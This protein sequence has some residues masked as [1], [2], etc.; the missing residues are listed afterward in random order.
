MHAPLIRTLDATISCGAAFRRTAGDFHGCLSNI[1]LNRAS[2]RISLHR[3]YQAFSLSDGVFLTSPCLSGT[4]LSCRWD[5]V[6]PPPTEI[7][8]RQLRRARRR[9]TPLSIRAEH[10]D[11]RDMR[12]QACSILH[13]SSVSIPCTGQPLTR[14]LPSTPKIATAFETLLAGV[15][16]S[17]GSLALRIRVTPLERGIAPDAIRDRSS[18]RRAP[19][20]GRTISPGNLLALTH[21]RLRRARGVTLSADTVLSR[22]CCWRRCRAQVTAFFCLRTAPQYNL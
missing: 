11:S 13:I 12:W 19:E 18:R 7:P 8:I 22:T 5:D 3:G 16:I 10:A 21:K 1:T 15:L 4:H 2:L 9:G 17:V 6:S 14:F 20:T